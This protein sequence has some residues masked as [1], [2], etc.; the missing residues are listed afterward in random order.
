MKKTLLLMLALLVWT[1]VSCGQSGAKGEQHEPP[2][3]QV[4]EQAADTA[5]TGVAV[6]RAVD[7]S[8]SGEAAFKT[9]MDTYAGEVVVLDFWATWCPPCRRAMVEVDRI[10]PE[11]MSKG[12]RFVY[13]T[14]ETSPQADF[15]KM[16]PGIHGDHYRLTNKQWE[17]VC[18]MLNLPGIP[19]YAVVCRDGS[20]QYSNLSQGGYPGNE[21][22]QNAAEVALTK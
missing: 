13:I 16:M 2:A 6:L 1:S 10:K 9:I 21:V 4:D 7:A 3:A 17:E 12:V 20:M 5:T 18:K 15:N 14:G 22:I 19:A 8:L 11:L